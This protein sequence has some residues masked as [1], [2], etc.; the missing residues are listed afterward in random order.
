V[1]APTA[2]RERFP[3]PE[4]I[5][6]GIRQPWIELILRGVKTLEI[7]SR[8]TR[9]RGTIY[10]Y[11]SKQ[12]SNLPAAGIAARRHALDVTS[13][14]C[15]LLLGSVELCGTRP[16]TPR[17]AQAACVPTAHLAGQFAWD[18]QNPQRFAHPLPVKSLPYGVWFYPFR[19]RRREA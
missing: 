18:L 6:L 3:N 16:A 14:P 11:A 5:A 4:V 15:G 2:D 8:N 1:S 9:I 19:R 7:R 10:L 17:D 12:L 13:L